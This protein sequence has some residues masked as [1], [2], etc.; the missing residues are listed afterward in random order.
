MTKIDLAKSVILKIKGD[1][2][3]PCNLSIDLGNGEI[4]NDGGLIVLSRSELLYLISLQVENKEIFSRLKL[5][6]VDFPKIYT[7]LAIEE[8]C[9]FYEILAEIAIKRTNI[10]VPEYL[11][12]DELLKKDISCFGGSSEYLDN[13]VNGFAYILNGILSGSITDKD[14]DA[15]LYYYEY[16]GNDFLTPLEMDGLVK[17]RVFKIHSQLDNQ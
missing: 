4:H 2:A 16:E 8:Y 13:Y 12:K 15:Y 5:T 3:L 11:S 10:Q 17:N 9:S 6:H 7:E 1:K 14:V